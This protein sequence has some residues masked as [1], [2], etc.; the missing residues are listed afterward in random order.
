MQTE[1]R[2]IIKLSHKTFGGSHTENSDHMGTK[3]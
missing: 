3:G 2:K 1:T